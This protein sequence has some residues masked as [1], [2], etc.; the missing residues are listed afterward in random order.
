MTRPLYP[1]LCLA[2][3]LLGPRLGR[4]SPPTDC[5][6][7]AD[8][9]ENDALRAPMRARGFQPPPRFRALL[10]L[11]ELAPGGRRIVRHRLLAWGKQAS[12]H[13]GWNPASTVK[14]FS[15]ISALELVRR[16]GF[17]VN[18]E[19]TFHYPRGAQTFALKELFEDAVHWS[20][21]VPHNRLVQLAGFDNLNGPGG[22]L[23]RAGLEHTFIMTAYAQTAW[24]AEGHPP[25][26][27]ES[28]RITLQEGKRRRQVPARRSSLRV[29]CGSS[30]CTTL[31]DLAKTMCR[32]MLHEQLPAERRFRLGGDGQ[33]P[34]LKL[35]RQAMESK[36]RGSH[37]PVWDVMERR[38][39]PSRGYLLFRKAGFSQGWLSENMYIYRRRSRQ[40]WIVALAGL[41]G[42]DTLTRAAET[43]A[44]LISSG[45]IK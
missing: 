2:V 3:L 11:T 30:A 44:R 16:H 9:I 4:A 35:L 6:W 39:P 33:S 8:Q 20:K 7:G 41:G 29:P 45:E 13:Q 23:Q 40:R 26:L 17:G 34:H 15:A 37:D 14:L 22:T 36:R 18:A 38:F 43:I 24:T 28:P 25:S 10:V 42:R 21:N 32:M 12:D 1:A 19:V 27:R 5:T 31:S